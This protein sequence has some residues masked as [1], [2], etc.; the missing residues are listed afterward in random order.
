MKMGHVTVRTDKFSEETA[1]YQEIAGLKIVRDLRERGSE[2][3]FLADQENETRIEVIS[4]KQAV[5][6]GSEW[7][8]IGFHTEDA[9]KLRDELR[10]K[11][12]TVSEITSPAP[13]VRF[14]FV[15]DPA[16]VNV[17]FVEERN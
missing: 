2:I 9:G 6:S 8:S 4:V 1:F 17:Q 7:L 11:G 5:N 3:V 15:K 10:M 12:L 16:G 14:F 13:S